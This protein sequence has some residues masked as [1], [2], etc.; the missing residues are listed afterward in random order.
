MQEKKYVGLEPCVDAKGY[1]SHG[2]WSTLKEIVEVEA[3]RDNEP[4]TDFPDLLLEAFG[5]RPAIWVTTDPF[6]AY[7]YNISASEWNEEAE[8]V[9]ARYPE[10]MEDVEVVRCEGCMKVLGTDDGDGG[11]LIVDLY[12]EAPGYHS[13]KGA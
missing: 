11:F 1:N 5:E 4:F 3:E 2:Y 7:R 10:W 12:D 6:E 9:K 13:S 8:V